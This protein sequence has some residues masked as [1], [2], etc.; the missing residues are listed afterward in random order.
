MKHFDEHSLELYVVASAKV[1]GKRR[2]IEAHLA[3]CPDCKRRV[4]Q[5]QEFYAGVNQEISRGA[6]RRTDLPEV[7]VAGEN[8]S[9]I[10]R[11]GTIP[12]RPSERL[13]VPAPVYAFFRHHPVTAGVG[14]MSFLG[15]M[16]WGIGS[17][18]GSRPSE[19]QPAYVQYNIAA[20]T[21]DVYDKTDRKI[22]QKPAMHL[23]HV[24]EAEEM[25]GIHYTLLADLDN[26]GKTSIVTTA[27]LGGLDDDGLSNR[28][29][30]FDEH[31]NLTAMC[32]TGRLVTFAGRVYPLDYGPGGILTWEDSSSYQREILANAVGFRS[33]SVLTRMDARGRILGEYWHY[34][35]FGGIYKVR[36]LSP[37]PADYA[38]LTGI[39]DAADS[40]GIS[41]GAIVVLD[42]LKIIG[43]SESSASRGFG[44]DK[45]SAEVYYIRLP[46][47]DVYRAFGGKYGVRSLR[48]NADQWLSFLV[49]QITKDV[50]IEFVFSRNMVLKEVRPTDG[51]DRLHAQLL[52]ERKISSTYDASYLESL[53]RGVQYWDGRQWRNEVVTVQQ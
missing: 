34:G 43:T 27:Q 32:S 22:G 5:M 14:I 44:F 49:H 16:I 18:V 8:P 50:A 1:A 51:F 23:D 26:D 47:S 15:L 28:V 25:R 6:L 24:V 40:A 39:N 37:R 35:H 42:P 45:A 48:A 33:P 21:L 36:L 4:T 29:K 17:L 13:S 52:K 38:V 30:I 46:E 20:G 7:I 53:K 10:R 11:T 3:R 9:V 31:M 19:I 41:F 12:V 2:S